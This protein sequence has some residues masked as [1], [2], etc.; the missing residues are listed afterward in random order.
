MRR[1]SRVVTLVATVILTLATV[2][3]VFC[4]DCSPESCQFSRS[5]SQHSP[6][7][8]SG[9]DCLC[10]CAHIVVVTMPRIEPTAQT[11]PTFETTVPSLQIVPSRPL[12]HPPQ[13]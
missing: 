10:C 6:I 5:S 13:A 7:S 12:F 8:H 3:I 1:F 2:E 9:D 4:S 11:L